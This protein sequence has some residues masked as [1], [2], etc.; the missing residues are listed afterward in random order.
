MNEI[1]IKKYRGHSPGATHT[2]TVPPDPRTGKPLLPLMDPGTCF[3]DEDEDG[4]GPTLKILEA[5]TRPRMVT[6]G[7]DHRI[8]ITHF[9]LAREVVL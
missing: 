4:L 7:L 5:V 1:D 6:G 8:E 3:Q 2:I 9:Y